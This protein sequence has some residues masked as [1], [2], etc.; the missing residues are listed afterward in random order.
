[1][2][3]KYDKYI[4]DIKK[5]YETGILTI[6]DINKKYGIKSHTFVSSILNDKKRN[7]SEISKLTRKTYPEK[8]KMSEDTKNKIRIARYKFLK[9]HP[10]QT[11]WRK[12]N[13]PSYPE[14][15][16]IKFLE[17]N[18]YNKKYLIEREYP[19]FPYYIDFA[20]VDEKLAVEIDGGQHLEHD[21]KEKDEKK[22]NF[23]ISIGWKI[24]RISEST[25]KNDW[26]LIKLSIENMLN[27]DNVYEKVGLLKHKKEKNVIK[28]RDEF[29]RTTKQSE[30]CISQR[31]VKNRPDK[32]NLIKILTEKKN[33]V[34]VGK[35]FNVS[36]NC[37]R[38]WCKWYKIP[39]TIKYYK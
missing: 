33:F 7:R 10:E 35:Q 34:E 21:R 28:E 16:F 26:D 38:K 19:I 14:K 24:L 12:R 15:C 22:D 23:L 2:A 32:E 18:E 8:F 27:S 25:V 29:G 30:H 20:F 13:E 1:M 5:D 4:D 11:A 31:V 36:D 3:S 9:E 17:K 6:Q 37:I 39:S